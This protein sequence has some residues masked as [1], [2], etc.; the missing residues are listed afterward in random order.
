MWC[1][2]KN[3]NF[4]VLRRIEKESNLECELVLQSCEDLGFT[5]KLDLKRK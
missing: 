2:K 3:Q 5:E 4:G 1:P